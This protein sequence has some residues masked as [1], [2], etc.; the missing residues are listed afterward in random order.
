MEN[1][2][3]FPSSF[4]TTI[5]SARASH[6]SDAAIETFNRAHDMVRAYDDRVWSSGL[7]LVPANFRGS[8]MLFIVCN[9]SMARSKTNVPPPAQNIE[10][11]EE[12]PDNNKFCIL[13][14]NAR[15]D[16]PERLFRVIKLYLAYHYKSTRGK[17]LQYFEGWEATVR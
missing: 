7:V 17:E 14:M 13:A 3:V 8:W 4:F 12:K 2:V 6:S 15:G 9:A 16:T 10:P 5:V 1:V 11:G